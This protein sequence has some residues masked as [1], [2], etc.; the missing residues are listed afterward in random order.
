MAAVLN[1]EEG[2]WE[3]V[4]HSNL[5]ITTCELVRFIQIMDKLEAKDKDLPPRDKVQL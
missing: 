1:L 2:G 5:G 4:S 3:T